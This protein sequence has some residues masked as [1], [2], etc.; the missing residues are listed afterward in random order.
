MPRNCWL[1]TR[2]QD[3]NLF[4]CK[5]YFNPACNSYVVF[6]YN[7]PVYVLGAF[8][9]N[10]WVYT[11]FFSYFYRFLILSVFGLPQPF[12]LARTLNIFWSPI[13]TS[14]L[15]VDGGKNTPYS[16]VQNITAKKI[17]GVLL[18]ALLSSVGPRTMHSP[19]WQLLKKLWLRTFVPYYAR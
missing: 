13:K 14:L 6:R 7:L 1:P 15:G 16:G 11:S 17:I 8:C 2:F 4:S 18:L 19:C 10:N 3:F 9:L 12:Y 5:T